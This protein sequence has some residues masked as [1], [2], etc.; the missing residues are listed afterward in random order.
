MIFRNGFPELLQRPVTRRMLR[1]IEVQN[2]P[3]CMLNHNEYVEDLERRHRHGEEVTGHDGFSMV[4]DEGRPALVGA[5]PSWPTTNLPTPF[6]ES[7][8]EH[9]VAM[10]AGQAET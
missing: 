3:R 6:G 4:A 7:M 9:R 1:D 10:Q 2:P 8:P 5:S